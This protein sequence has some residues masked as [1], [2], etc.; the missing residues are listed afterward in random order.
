MT[1]HGPRPRYPHAFRLRR[2]APAG[3]SLLDCP[4]DGGTGA[5]RG[6]QHSLRAKLTLLNVTLLALAVVTATCAGVLAMIIYLEEGVDSRLLAS[7]AGLAD[8]GLTT[9]KIEELGKLAALQ[10]AIS[11]GAG[12]LTGHVE[13]FVLVSSEGTALSFG[14]D[15]PSDTQ[16]ALAAA[17]GDPVALAAA[18]EPRAVSAEGV[19]YRVTAVRLEDGPCVLIA[20]STAAVHHAVQRVVKLDLA[21]GSVLLLALAAATLGGSRRRLR[22]L[23][24]M[25]AAAS[26][27]AEGDLDLSRRVTARGRPAAEV[28]QLRL[29]LNAMLQQLE[30]AFRTREQAAG[31]LR[32]FVADASHELRTPLSS[33]LGYLELYD[34]GMLHDEDSEARALR[35]MRAEAAR[36]AKLVD[37]LLVL[38]R[39]DQHPLDRP[40]PLDLA[41]LARDGAADLRAQ[42]PERPVRV[43]APEAVTLL[44]DE[45]ALRKVVANLL[46]N[47]RTHTPPTAPVTV[48]VSAGA[49]GSG[50]A[51]LTVADSG[52]GVRPEDTERV[53]DRFYRAGGGPGEDAGPATGGGS[54]LGLSIVRAVVEA[55]GGTVGVAAAPG[56]GLTVTVALPVGGA[57]GRAPE[58]PGGIRAV[59]GPV[60]G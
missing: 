47:V 13:R 59:T 35:R 33:I 15:A 1:R 17:A 22:P 44:G 31:Q 34:K 28:E 49:G 41:V 56:R 30:T 24:D 10:H 11:P 2:G 55:H 38:A 12:Q 36:M 7:R 25:V 40:E 48:S 54:G 53:F 3:R 4:V 19:P 29:A 9:G 52:P 50:T 16:R 6:R 14:P 32:R 51:V 39:L 58:G 42:Q 57:A 43:E 8:A 26:A 23:E 27:V 37:E 5:R 60:P 18:A 21:V 46:S 20:S 45:S